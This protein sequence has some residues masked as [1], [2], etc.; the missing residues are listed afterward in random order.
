MRRLTLLLLLPVAAGKPLLAQ[1]P[2][3]TPPPCRAAASRPAPVRPVLPLDDN[4]WIVL[5]FENQ[6]HAADLDWLKDASANLLYLDLS[7]WSDVH[8]VDDKRVA[9]FLREL[10]SARAGQRLTL[11]DAQGVARRAGAGRLVLGQFLKLGGRTRVSA[12]AY[13][14]RTGSSIR[15]VQEETAVID[16]L[17]PLFG[18]LAI[19]LLA[20]PLP[21]G[22]SVSIGTT[23]ADAY[24]EYLR[25]VAA[26]NR[27]DV[28]E[29]R[30]HLNKALA[31]DSTFALA[32]YRL[33]IASIYDEAAANA[34]LAAQASPSNQ[35]IL[36]TGTRDPELEANAA[37]AARLATGLPARE[38][39]LINGLLAHTKGDFARACELYGGLVRADSNDVEA[40]YGV[41][42]CSYKDDAVLF[43]GGDST[44]PAF[45]SSWNTTLRVLRRAVSV[46]PTFHLAFDHI[47]DV[48]TAT[49]RV[50]CARSAPD[51]PCEVAVSGPQQAQIY[52]A[53]MRRDGD[54]LVNIPFHAQVPA[55]IIAR[56]A[57]SGRAD[58]RRRNL[59]EARAAASDWVAAGPDEGRAHRTLGRI[60]L[61]LGRVD[62]ADHEM[63]EAA[64]LL[65]KDDYSDLSFFRIEIAL[66]L[67][68]GVEVN[69]LY[70]STMIVQKVAP[71]KVGAGI[72]FGPL[73]GRLSSADSSVLGS[74][75]SAGARQAPE[76]I[77]RLF[78]LIQR[79][80]LG[81]ALDSV[82][83]LEHDVFQLFN[84][85]TCRTD[86]ALLLGPL[87][88]FGLRA[89][90][91]RWIPFD[92]NATDRRLAPARALASGDTAALWKAAHMLDTAVAADLKASLPEDG[93]SLVAADAFLI[94]RDTASA[95]HQVSRMLDSTLRFTGIEGPVM[96]IGVL[97]SGFMWPRAMLLRADL[98][99]ARGNA[100]EARKW[101]Q[102]LAELWGKADAEVKKSANCER[103]TVNGT[104]PAG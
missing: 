26:L 57:E 80:G 1:C 94:L 92:S 104:C 14:A 42:R 84:Q 102:R 4:T 81:L 11:G 78:L 35:G 55:A 83:P 18:K 10:P 39:A 32:H 30:K 87:Q 13:D 89:P 27:F 6:A 23:R 51:V 60:L 69:R 88:S 86:C 34:R 31:L 100:A 50:G 67:G 48:L 97:F 5:P 70:D 45:R 20:L 24:Q 49:T 71:I 77:K 72:L 3:G 76:P 73:L 7:R 90:R 2:D 46:D 12:T 29:A 28:A 9:D 93:S 103:R 43:A 85:P 41:G 75:R 16:S 66:K 63:A 19:G 58:T 62:E 79:V 68:R 37:A 40:L 95:L 59:E 25:G 33:A 21:A 52:L 38:R 36:L 101:R 98:E 44:R 47:L 56:L 53:P 54:S 15:S 22:G 17:L 91:Q 61:K 65:V 82:A 99:A 8:A 64:R 74:L 96:P